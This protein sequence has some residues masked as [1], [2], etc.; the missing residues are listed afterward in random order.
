MSGQ[1]IIFYIAVSF[2]FI[3][4]LQKIRAIDIFVVTMI[5]KRLE[6]AG[7]SYTCNSKLEYSIKD[8]IISII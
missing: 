5:L 4:F 3:I 8:E 1:K 7:K 2:L 6:C